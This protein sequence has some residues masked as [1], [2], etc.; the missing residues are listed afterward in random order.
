M[1]L[2]LTLGLATLLSATSLYAGEKNCRDCPSSSSS[3]DFER[4]YDAAYNNSEGQVIST[5]DTFTPISFPF[6][7]PGTPV[8][9]SHPYLSDNTKFKITHSG[10]YFMAWT[11]T[12][13]DASSTETTQVQLFNFTTGQPINP[14]PFQTIDQFVGPDADSVSG[15]TLLRLQ[16]GTV[17]QL[18]VS[19]STG[20][21]SVLDPTFIIMRIAE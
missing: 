14:N 19:S 8:K 3:S 1:H 4:A 7:Q 21:V 15:Q 6:N 13:S 12:I 10:V 20:S 16:A 2:V 9:I 17:L 5:P 18:R 11:L